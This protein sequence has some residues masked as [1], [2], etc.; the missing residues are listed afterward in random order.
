MEPRILLVEDN[1]FSRDMMSRRL[2]KRGFE[3]LLACDGY[4]AIQKGLSQRPDLILMDLSLPMMDGWNASIC[5][6]VD[7]YGRVVTATDMDNCC[8]VA[9]SYWF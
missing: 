5:E 4:E 7:G 2:R 1:D 3:I 6:M 9:V 8:Y